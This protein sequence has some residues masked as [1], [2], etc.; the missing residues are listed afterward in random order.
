MFDV[1][2]E[3]DR[4]VKFYRNGPQRKV[5]PD[6]LRP[7]AADSS[8]FRE[9]VGICYEA[10]GGN[11]E[12]VAAIKGYLKAQRELRAKGIEALEAGIAAVAGGR[13]RTSRKK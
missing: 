11:P 12:P 8:G 13:I 1:R 4:E 7:S 10:V 6:S 9:V 5:F 2:Y 3:G